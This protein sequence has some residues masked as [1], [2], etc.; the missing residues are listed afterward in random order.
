MVCGPEVSRVGRCCGV[1]DASG[2]RGGLES[3]KGTTASRRVLQGRSVGSTAEQ[4][5]RGSV[6]S[7]VV[8]GMA[9]QP[10]DGCHAGFSTLVSRSVLCW[11]RTPRSAT[12]ASSNP[13]DSEGCFGRKRGHP[14][15]PVSQGHSHVD[16]AS[17]KG[18]LQRRGS[19]VCCRLA[20]ECLNRT[21]RHPETRH[22]LHG[23]FHRLAQLG[24][25]C[26]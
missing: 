5:V 14:G 6:L 23:R 22:E 12:R 19:S 3:P 18:R 13:R 15:I 8:P 7:S 10:D 20:A 1:S 11:S 25:G 4:D 17:G 21:K 26:P 9:A 24:N 2:G 16:G